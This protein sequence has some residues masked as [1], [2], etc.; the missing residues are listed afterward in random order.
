MG[1]AGG[2][3]F[4]RGVH[5]SRHLS[6]FVGRARLERPSVSVRHGGGSGSYACLHQPWRHEDPVCPRLIQWVAF[7]RS[8]WAVAVLDRMVLPG[9]RTD[10]H[11]SHLPTSGCLRRSLL[12]IGQ[13]AQAVVS[14]D[15]TAL[16]LSEPSF[17]TYAGPTAPLRPVLPDTSDSAMRVAILRVPE[18]FAPAGASSATLVLPTAT[19]SESP[20]RSRWLVAAGGWLLGCPTPSSPYLSTF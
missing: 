5:Y 17:V 7:P 1:S 2:F 8:A 20:S 19:S 12:D 10:R 11:F 6:E 14:S 3:L 9:G 16:P 13:N 15:E 18:P 4:R